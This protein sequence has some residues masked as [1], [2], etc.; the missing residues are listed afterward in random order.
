MLSKCAADTY[1]DT[2]PDTI[3][4]AYRAPR[5]GSQGP[6]YILIIMLYNISLYLLHVN[7]MHVHSSLL[8]LLLRLITV[9]DTVTAT[10]TVTA[11]V[12]VTAVVTVSVT[13][14]V[15]AT[16][17]VTATVTAGLVLGLDLDLNVDLDYWAFLLPTDT[18]LPGA[19][20]PASH[21]R[22]ADWR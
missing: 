16:A 18:Q 2:Y 10:A 22:P 17:N 3:M 12:T 19:A 15:T 4:G 20:G 9:T 5:W 7:Y 11:T 14:T 21:M 13:V 6:R 8:R 1:P